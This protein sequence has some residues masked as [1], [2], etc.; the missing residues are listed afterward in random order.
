[1]HTKNGPETTKNRSKNGPKSIKNRSEI[2]AK[3]MIGYKMASWMHLG[4][5][6]GYLGAQKMG[7]RIPSFEQRSEPTPILTEI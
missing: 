1:M 2:D 4:C 5:L 6:G 3:M 7:R